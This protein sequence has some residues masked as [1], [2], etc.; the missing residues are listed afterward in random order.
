MN[1]ADD[2]ISGIPGEHLVRQGFSDLRRGQ[3]TIPACLVSIAKTRLCSS[4]VFDCAALVFVPDPEH[5]LYRLLRQEGGDAY[6][7]YNSLL[8]ELV[9]F[10]QALD[11][12]VG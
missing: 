12:V 9:S 4:G 6:S 1:T 5:E 7:R 2:I 10:C 3:F 11:H 8:R